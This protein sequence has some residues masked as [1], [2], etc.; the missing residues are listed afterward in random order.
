MSPYLFNL[1]TEFIF[2]E[3]DHFPGVKIGGRNINNLR[4]ADDT[5]L[6]AEN[7]D[8]LQNLTTTIQNK[9]LVAGL[10]M[11]IRKTK[12]MVMERRE[13]SKPEIKINDE[14]LEQVEKFRYLGQ[15]ISANGNSKDE[16]KTRI[17][18]AKSRFGQ[19]KNILTSSRTQIKTRLNV[20]QCYVHSAVLY[21]C[22]TL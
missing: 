9:S 3:T 5:V 7:V 19:L 20:L 12:I 8:D 15:L 18:I 4:Y 21:G 1:Y 2:R 14:K 10:E 6:L 13:S 22:E 11:N 16:V 17:G